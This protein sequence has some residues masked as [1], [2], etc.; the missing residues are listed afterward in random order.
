MVSA[1]RPQVEIA[2]L[3]QIAR[4]KRLLHDRVYSVRPPAYGSV[5]RSTPPIKAELDRGG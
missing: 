2:V 4:G 3:L 1:D 5:L